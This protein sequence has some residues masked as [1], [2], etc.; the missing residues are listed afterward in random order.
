[1]ATVAVAT[2]LTTVV[3]DDDY[4]EGDVVFVKGNE[5][6]SMLNPFSW[7]MTAE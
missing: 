4:D 2:V 7:F 3:H 5:E 6:R 1:V